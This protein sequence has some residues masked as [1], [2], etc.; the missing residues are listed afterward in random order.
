MSSDAQEDFNSKRHFASRLASAVERDGRT[1]GAIAL[2]MGIH[3]PAL[4]RWLGGVIPD[5]DNLSKLAK[6][7]NVSVQWLLTGD[8]NGVNEEPA[9]YKIATRIAAPGSGSSKGPNPQPQTSQA[10]LQTCQFLLT[11]F[12]SIQSAEALDWAIQ[13]VHEALR[14]YRTLKLEEINS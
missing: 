7:L 14:R 10:M 4:S 9:L 12:D 1:K 3:P 5:P 13:G 2:S 11:Q 6:A 8:G